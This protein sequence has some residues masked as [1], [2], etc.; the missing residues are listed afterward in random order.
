MESIGFSCLSFLALLLLLGSNSFHPSPL[1]HPIPAHLR[2]RVHSSVTP[3]R[4]VSTLFSRTWRQGYQAGGKPLLVLSPAKP[5]AGSA[6]PPT[7]RYSRFGGLESWHVVIS[8]LSSPE[9]SIPST[10]ESGSSPEGHMHIS[11]P[12]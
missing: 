1:L 11:N 6:R 3:R 4:S 5:E 8:K 10:T 12:T 7:I 2:K 9:R